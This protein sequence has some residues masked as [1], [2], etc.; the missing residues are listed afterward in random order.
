MTSFARVVNSKWWN[1]GV[2]WGPSFFLNNI[3]NLKGNCVTYIHTYIHTYMHTRLW[4]INSLKGC[5][6]KRPKCKPLGNLY[7]ITPSWHLPVKYLLPSDW[8]YRVENESS[9]LWHTKMMSEWHVPIMPTSYGE[10][11]HHSLINVM[12]NGPTL[13]P[14]VH[15]LKK[16]PHRRYR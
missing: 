11:Y 8:H 3:F 16:A 13:L 7:G 12:V 9:S 14:H 5:Y 10:R 4:L 15:Q 2:F 1:Y 6:L